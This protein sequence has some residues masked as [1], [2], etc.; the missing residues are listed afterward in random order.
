MAEERTEQSLRTCLDELGESCCRQLQ[1]IASDMWQPYLKVLAARAG[2]VI[3]VLDR[4]HIMQK[5]GKALDEI[6]ADE[7]KRLK[8]GGYEPV[9]T[10]SRWC[11]LKRPE[12]LTDAQSLRLS[13]LLHYNLK[14]VRADLLKEEFQ[15][16]WVYVS[17]KWAGKFLDHWTT[18]VMR[19]RLDRRPH[20]TR[21]SRV[22]LEL[23]QSQRPNL[24]RCRRRLKQPS[25]ARLQ[26]TPRLPNLASRRTRSPP[27]TWKPP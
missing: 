16:F 21:P 24:Q 4:F 2:Q 14:A 11:L 6:R 20:L 3:H 18:K 26:K 23:V 15:Q 17:A 8:A 10:K 9:L 13:E 27:P 12:N 22:D 1:F 19:S 5:F 7:T 25:Q